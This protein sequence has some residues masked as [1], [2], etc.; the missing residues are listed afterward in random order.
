MQSGRTSNAGQ[1]RNRMLR[2]PLRT[3]ALML[4]LSGTSAGAQ[5]PRPAVGSEQTPSG[6]GMQAGSALA[7]IVYFPFKAATAIGGGIAGG[8]GYL[9]SGGSQSAANAVWEPS[10][11]GT[12]VITP[13]H[14]AGRKP[15]QFFGKTPSPTPQ[16]R[17]TPAR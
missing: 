2:A 6:I 11:Y 16:P 10:I 3:V 17:P 7:T 12:Y 4:L 5:A 9:F 15:V 8:L 14:L 1:A 13:D